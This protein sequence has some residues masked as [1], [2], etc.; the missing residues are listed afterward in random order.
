MTEQAPA[1]APVPGLV[2]RPAYAV[3][4]GGTGARPAS[5]YG[6]GAQA[7][8][9]LLGLETGGRGTQRR[10]RIELRLEESGGACLEAY[11]LVSA[12]DGVTIT[13]AGRAGLLHGVR[14]LAQ[15]GA[16]PPLGEIVD[17]PR[18]A[19]RGGMLDVA[20]HFFGVPEV[21]D[22][23]DLLAAY[24]FN[25]LH[26]H[27]TDDQ[28]WRIAVGALP[29]LAEVGGAGGYYSAEDYRRIVSYAGERHITV[30]P[31]VDLPGHTN[32]ALAAYPEL[33]VPG[34][35]SQLPYVEREVGRSRVDTDSERVF[36]FVDT[37]VRELAA[38]TPGPLLHVGGDEA[39]RIGAADYARF[40]TRVG[41]IVRAH[42]KQPMAWDEAALAGPATVDVVQVWRPRRHTGPPVDEAVRAA[43]R[44]GARLVMSPADRT[45]LD[46]KYDADTPL[47]TDWAGTVGL[48]DAYDWDPAAY[49]PGLPG[50]AVVG[51]E[52]PLWTETIADAAG[53]QRMLLPR[54]PAIAEVAWSPQQV[55]DWDDFARRITAH[56]RLWTADRLAW[57]A[58]DGV[59][60]AAGS[61]AA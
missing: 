50:G 51:V 9:R 12:T 45:Y 54:L 11:R 13:A 3:W 23:V 26:L 1:P 59:D 57:T 39:L 55:R 24:K 4:T 18:Y 40:M 28:G 17:A 60:W 19:Y 37:V 16:A 46:M 41:G 25:H 32:A 22:Y 43:A 27:L 58:A 21:L 61:G 20:R 8:A 33:A 48:R 7:A 14:T 30:V 5:V 44:G 47:G 52:A 38:L 15:L 53:L 49:L 2:P 29:R 42:G 36:A 56:G 31:E 6:E 10:G 35:T 34:E